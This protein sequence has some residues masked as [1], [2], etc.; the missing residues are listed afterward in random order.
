MG[1]K[2]TNEVLMDLTAIGNYENKKYQMLFGRDE[3]LTAALATGAIDGEVSST[4]NFMSFN[5]PLATLYNKYD[6][7]SRD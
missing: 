2:F 6:K 3:Q 7:D 5:L 4:I 1:V